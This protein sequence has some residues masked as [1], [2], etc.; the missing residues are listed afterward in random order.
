MRIVLALIFIGNSLLLSAQQRVLDSLDVSGISTNNPYQLI[1]KANYYLNV[2]PDSAVMHGVKAMQSTSSIHIDQLLNAYLVTGKGYYWKGN[3][4]TSLYCFEKGQHLADSAKSKTL[5]ALFDVELGKLLKVLLKYDKGLEHLL[6]A[7]AYFENEGTA[8]QHAYTCISLMEFYRAINKPNSGEELVNTVLRLQ[9]QSGLSDETL[10]YFYHRWASLKT[11]AGALIKAKEL[12]LKSLEFS[13]KIN[14]KHYR[15]TSYNELGY[16]IFHD[17][18]GEGIEYYSKA[19]KLWE[20]IGY[21]RYMAHVQTNISRLYLSKLEYEKCI[22]KLEHCLEYATMNNWLGIEITV[23]QL[24]QQA[25]S[26]LND[27]KNANIYALKA[28]DLQIKFEKSKYSKGLLELQTKYETEKKERQ[29]IQQE[30]EIEKSKVEADK[31]TRQRNTILMGTGALV[32]LVLLLL[33]LYRKLR[34]ANNKLAQKQDEVLNINEELKA[35]L[36]QKEALL[37]EIHHR[38]KNNMQKVISLLNLQ[39]YGSSNDEVQRALRDSQGRIKAMA[40]IHEKLYTEKN[41]DQIPM[42]T[43]FE[44][45]METLMQLYETPEQSFSYDID[46]SDIIMSIDQAIPLGLIVNELITNSFKYAFTDVTE[47]TLSIQLQ[48]SGNDYTLTVTDNGPGL[49]QNLNI[50]ETESLGLQL[51][52]LFSEQLNGDL[53]HHSKDGAHF[54]LTFTV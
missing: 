35:T 32:V 41:L 4:E 47:G 38:V 1:E 53:V 20:E 25:Y 31:N 15:A 16:I 30:K 44:N 8:E 18:S 13:E 33:L 49:P 14:H 27:F 10:A 19:E 43:Y 36:S 5:S 2:S 22:K 26:G 12:S 52:S 54:Q 6:N 42:E 9:R 48:K 21:Y 11:V 29:L 34:K 17:G 40:L 7:L 3:Y 51:V 46:A 28:S 50:E 24:Y 37:K 45:L 39:I 23:Y